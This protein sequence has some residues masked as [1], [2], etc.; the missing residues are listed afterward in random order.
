MVYRRRL[1]IRASARK[2]RA[3]RRRH[4]PLACRSSCSAICASAAAESL[5]HSVCELSPPDAHSNP[6]SSIDLAEEAGSRENRGTG[7]GA[8][9]GDYLERG[10]RPDWLAATSRFRPKWRRAP[11]DGLSK[12]KPPARHL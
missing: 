7:H 2:F 9:P 11:S 10:A 5:W 12:G 4:L 8:R 1:P 6:R 3:H